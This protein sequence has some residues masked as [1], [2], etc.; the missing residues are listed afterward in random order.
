MHRY[1]QKQVSV[2]ATNIACLVI[3]AL[4]TMFICLV[5]SFGPVLSPPRMLT[6]GSD[7]CPFD[8]S[9]M[10]FFKLYANSQDSC[11]LSVEVK[12][13]G[14][15]RSCCFCVQCRWKDSARNSR[16][17]RLSGSRGSP[18]LD[19]VA[20]YQRDQVC[21]DQADSDMRPGTLCICFPTDPV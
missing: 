19:Y 4:G 6:L 1:S 21:Q 8:E 12:V 17:F 3:S 15:W 13:E 9:L 7:R 14:C 2:W 16:K 18:Q 10:A 5:I 11:H 20:P